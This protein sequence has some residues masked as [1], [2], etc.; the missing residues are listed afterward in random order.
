LVGVAATVVV[1]V[2]AARAS[3]MGLARAE[4]AKRA[5][6]ERMVEVFMVEGGF[7]ER[8]FWLVFLILILG[9]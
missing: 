8:G 2:V 5:R 6:V 3:T 1:V 4:A 7:G 9:I